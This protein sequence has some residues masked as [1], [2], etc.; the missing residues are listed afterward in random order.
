MNYQ[1]DFKETNICYQGI[2][3][4]DIPFLK[5]EQILNKQLIID[6]ISLNK[7]TFEIKMPKYKILI[8]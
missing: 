8:N 7:Q 2:Y 5:N 1:F 6:K 3:L 4:L